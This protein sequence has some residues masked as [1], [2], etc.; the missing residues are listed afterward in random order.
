MMRVLTVND[1]VYGVTVLDVSEQGL[2]VRAS[3]ALPVGSSIE[4]CIGDTSLLGTIRYCR[5]IDDEAFNMGIL[6][7]TAIDSPAID[8]YS[9]FGID[10]FAT[11][12]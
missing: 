9:L 10:V 8:L 12:I 4:V 6:V 3:R 2:R 1:G 5:E 7:S 11:P